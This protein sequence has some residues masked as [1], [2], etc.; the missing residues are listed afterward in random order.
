MHELVPGVDEA[1]S[2]KS[3]DEWGP[4][5]DEVGLIWG[6]V[7][8]I[9]EVASDP[10]A[11]AIGLFPTIEH[12]EAGTYRSVR[13]PMRFANATVEP[14]GPAPTLGADTQAILTEFGFGNAADLLA[15]GI[16]G[17]GS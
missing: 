7:L 5:F 11:E 4:I 3:R 10:Q 15:R 12:P 14:R 8:G 16:V 1:L 13:I 17:E 2:V 6:K 9:H